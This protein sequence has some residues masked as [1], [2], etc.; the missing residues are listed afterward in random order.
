MIAIEAVDGLPEI[1]EGDDLAALIADRSQPQ[2]GDIV[3]IAQKVVSKAEGRLRALADVTPSPEAERIAIQTDKDPRLVQL[4]LDESSQVL[5][6]VPG[7]LIVETH[8]GFVCANAGIDASNL[9]G[10]SDSLLLLPVDPDASARHL[11]SELQTRTGKQLAVLI[12]D[13]FGRAW[14]SGQADVAIGC[15]GIAPLQDLR[16]ETDRDGRELA[17]TVIATADEIAGAADLARAKDSG[18]PVVI[19]RGRGDLVTRDDGPGAA[20]GLRSRAEDLFRDAKTG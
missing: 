13:S 12:A 2:D 20:A 1:N 17:A 18:Q 19:V 15:A 8:H 7:V 9:A 5:R 10:A 16:G 6:A 11:R 4:I 3:V 14:R